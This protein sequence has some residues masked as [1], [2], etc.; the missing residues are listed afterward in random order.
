MLYTATLAITLDGLGREC[1]DSY[2]SGDDYFAL[3]V[4]MI[5]MAF[6]ELIMLWAKHTLKIEEFPNGCDV[7]PGEK[8]FR[9]VKCLAKLSFTISIVVCRHGMHPW[10]PKN[11]GI[12]RV[13]LRMLKVSHAFPVAS[14]AELYMT[15]CKLS[16]REKALKSRKKTNG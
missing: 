7:K 12:Q 15:V 3:Y 10:S 8:A 11:E 4:V 5:L 16:D 13:H 1:Q 2:M 9:T 6:L 14:S